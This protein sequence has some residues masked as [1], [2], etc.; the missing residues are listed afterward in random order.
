MVELLD[1]SEVANVSLSEEVDS[2]TLTTITATA[3]DTMNVVLTVSGQIVVDNQRNLLYI[4]TTSQQISGDKYTRRSRLELAHDKLTL[5]LL[6][7]T[8]HSRD[9]EILGIH[10]LSEPVYLPPGVTVDD[11][12]GNGEGLVQV[13]Q[14]AE[15]PLLLLYR[16][17]ELLDTFKGQ[18]ITLDK[19]ANGVAHKTARYLEYLEGHGSREEGN[20]HLLG[21]EA[22]HFVDLV[23]ETA[24]KH[25]ISLIED[26]EHDRVGADSVTAKHIPN[27]AG[28]SYHDVNTFLKDADIVANSGTT[29]TAVD[30]YAHEISEVDHYLLGLHSQLT[31][32]R[33]DNSLALVNIG[34]DL[35]QGSNSKSTSLTGT[36]LC[37]RDGIVSQKDG[38]DSA[39][40]DSGGV[41]ETYGEYTTEEV[42]AQVHSV[43][44]LGNLGPV[45][46][47]G[48]AISKASRGGLSDTGSSLLCAFSR[49]IGAHLL[50]FLLLLNLSHLFLSLSL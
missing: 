8:M 11:S 48:H 5:L 46:L 9:G 26:E 42:L 17:V 21:E 2:H 35:L 33:Q 36:G 38:L 31:G 41:L 13:A 15:L 45:G 20:L 32:G 6:H 29:N 18:F 25:L 49:C 23:T 4:N 10:L 39:L 19:N 28:G 50:H 22:E 37:L 47:Y 14:C 44:G 3:T 7:V 34:V 40:L 12:L 27:A 16:Y 43:E 30:L 1:I 24:R